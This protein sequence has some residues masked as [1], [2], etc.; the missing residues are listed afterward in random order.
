MLAS[1]LYC[2]IP[3]K[4]IPVLFFCHSK[5]YFL[6]FKASRWLEPQTPIFQSPF[7]FS[8]VWAANIYDLLKLTGNASLV[9]FVRGVYVMKLNHR[10]R[11]PNSHFQTECSHSHNEAN[12][13]FSQP[14]LFSSRFMQPRFFFFFGCVCSESLVLNANYLA[15][16]PILLV[17]QIMHPVPAELA[18][19]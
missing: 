10:I 12:F 8:S 3:L 1:P 18:E 16:R 15:P 5:P 13:T 17:F 2:S 7:F 9:H 11:G 19:L 14:L 4:R 6:T